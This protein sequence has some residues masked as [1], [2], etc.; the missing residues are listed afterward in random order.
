MEFSSRSEIQL[1]V[2]RPTI[3]KDIAMPLICLGKLGGL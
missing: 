3:A 2:D 1:K